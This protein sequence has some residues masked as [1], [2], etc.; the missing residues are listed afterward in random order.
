MVTRPLAAILACIVSLSAGC[1]TASSPP[2][3]RHSDAIAPSDASLRWSEIYRTGNKHLLLIPVAEATTDRKSQCWTRYHASAEQVG[4]NGSAITIRLRVTKEPA[5][6]CTAQAIRGPFYAAV[7]LPVP[8]S[9]QRLL[10]ADTE[11]AHQISGFR[12]V[13]TLKYPPM[14]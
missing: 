1:T 12:A 8:Y 2:A 10:V 9:G 14:Y 11:N 7:R 6:T 3:H 4:G 5:S 13:R